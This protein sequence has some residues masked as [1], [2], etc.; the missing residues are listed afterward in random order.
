[1]QRLEQTVFNAR[2]MFIEP[3]KVLVEIVF[4]KGTQ[5]ENVTRRVVAGKSD[6]GQPRPLV[7]HPCN[8]LP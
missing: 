6:R 2:L 4:V 1:M 5:A 7:D 3:V 8:H